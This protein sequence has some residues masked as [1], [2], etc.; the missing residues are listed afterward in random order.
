ME[1]EERIPL[2]DEILEPWRQRLGPDFRGY[3]NHVYR[4]VHFALAL[5]DHDEEERRKVVVAGAFHDL[6]IWS[7][8]TFDYLAPSIALAESWLRAEGL[9]AWVPEV[10][11]TIELHHKLTPHRDPRF[12]LVEAFRRAD[13]V[14]VSLGVV[15]FGLPRAFVRGVQQRFPDAGFHR[16]LLR[17]TARWWRR[18]PANPVPVL[19]W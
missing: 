5:R 17:L 12:P 2:L 19:R 9:E 14:D 11:R 4:V 13:L 15:R 7:A 6:G 1:I 18:H 16:L 3:R 8:G 10:A